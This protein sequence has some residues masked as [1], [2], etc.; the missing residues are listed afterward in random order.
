MHR[1][2]GAPHTISV[3]WWDTV[4]ELRKQACQTALRNM[5]LANV[6]ADDNA[7][8]P[9]IP[10]AGQQDEWTVGRIVIWYPNVLF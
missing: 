10:Q 9:K 8:P 2:K 1:K 3:Q 6:A 5:I 4:A 7:E